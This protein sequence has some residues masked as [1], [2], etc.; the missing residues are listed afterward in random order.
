MKTII[1]TVR[2]I[3]QDTILKTVFALVGLFIAGFAAFVLFVHP[4][5]IN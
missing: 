5:N 2:T 4:G 3:D 1:N